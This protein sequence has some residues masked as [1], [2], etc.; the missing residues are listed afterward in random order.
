LTTEQVAHYDLP[1]VPVKESDLRKA[2]FEAAHGSGQVELDALESLHP[3]ELENLVR[4]EILNYYD[5]NLRYRASQIRGELEARLYGLSSE[6]QDGHQD[7]LAA[8]QSDYEALITDYEQTQD[9]FDDLVKDFQADIDQYDAR[10]KSI[11]DWFSD[12][13]NQLD[14]ELND[15]TVDL[16]EYDL[17]EADLPDESSSLLY[18][19]Q[20]EYVDQLTAYKAYRAGRVYTNGKH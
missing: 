19:S 15:I 2:N 7:E 16:G 1:R 18:S 8:L 4:Q 17:P 14:R 10:L 5:P 13:Y 6:A 12:I 9:R 20:R 11:R 3:G